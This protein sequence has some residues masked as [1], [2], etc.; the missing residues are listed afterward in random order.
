MSQTQSTTKKLAVRT[1]AT[2]AAMSV[3]LVPFAFAADQTTTGTVTAVNTLT[4]SEGISLAPTLNVP[5]VDASTVLTF[6]TNDGTTN[7]ITVVATVWAF[8][9]A[10]T[11]S[12]ANA[13]PVLRFFSATSTFGAASGTPGVLIDA[14][15][16]ASAAVDVVTAITSMA[17]TATVTLDAT[18]SQTVVAGSYTTTLTYALVTP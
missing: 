18:I 15:N 11:A 3:L 4:V 8:T 6:D 2:L 12:E 10:V 16:L 1:F 9:P 14:G 17:G 7:R 13:Y 5:A